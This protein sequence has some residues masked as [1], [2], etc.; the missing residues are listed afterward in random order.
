MEYEGVG[1]LE[2][3]HDLVLGLGEIGVVGVVRIVQRILESIGR[4]VDDPDGALSGIP[5]I[6]YLE[7]S[8]EYPDDVLVGDRELVS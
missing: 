6:S 2:E 8:G 7:G 1:I 3:G 4:S 5:L